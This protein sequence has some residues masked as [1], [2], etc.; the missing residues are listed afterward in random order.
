MRGMDAEFGPDATIDHE[1]LVPPYRQ[2]ASIL[3]A[4]IE[5]GDYKPGRAIPSE[6]RLQQEFGL[7]RDT[8]RKAVRLLRDEGLLTVAAGRGAFVRP[9]V[10]QK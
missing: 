4:R 1:H 7:A 9:D 3:R 8:V 2:L 5:R 6:L 10:G